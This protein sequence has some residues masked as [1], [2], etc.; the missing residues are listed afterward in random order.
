[1]RVRERRAVVELALLAALTLAVGIGVSIYSRRV[2]GP[3]ERV[4]Q[5]AQAVARGD[6]TPQPVPE[7]DDEIGQLAGA[8]ERMVGAVAKAQSRAVA[9]ERLAAIGKM[10]AHVTHEIRNPL[11]SIGLNIE[12]LE[13][14]ITSAKTSGEA[15]SLLAAITR[16]VQRLEHLSEEYLR[17][18][19]LPQPRME[20][21]DLGA[22]VREIVA[23]A[24]PEIERA[25]LGVTVEVA[26][27]L[28]PA[29]F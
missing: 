15:K 24:K 21:E 1:A 18:A 5:R 22:K 4:T 17:V 25:G 11:S 19:R 26:D 2:L 28:P 3:L 9:N 23:F 12:L 20:S 27:D 7:P 8:F 10:A 13:E 6:L 16:E 14:E 29:L